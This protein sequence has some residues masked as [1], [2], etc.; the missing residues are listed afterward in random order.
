MPIFFGLFTMLR[1]SYEL[2][3]QPAFLWIQD[4][5][6]P[7]H[8]IYMGITK[9]PLLGDGL[10]YLNILPLVMMA[11]WVVSAFSAPLPDDPQQRSMQKMMRFMPLMFGIMLYSYAS[12]L[13]LYMCV[14]ALWTVIEQRI[15]KAKYGTIAAGTSPM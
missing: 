6:Q 2:R 4:L 14:S 7:D 11:L 3:H 9:L 10:E 15:I 5:S 12:G 1:A 8:A 13:A